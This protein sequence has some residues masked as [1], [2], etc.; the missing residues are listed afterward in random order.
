MKPIIH[1]PPIAKAPGRTLGLDVIARCEAILQQSPYLPLRRLTC[2]F[3]EGI[4]SIRGTV[5]SFHLKQQAQSALAG[6][7]G[8]EE[9][10][11]LVVVVGRHTG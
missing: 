3:H 7:P 6:V 1:T 4:L 9:L 10:Y 8:V 2:T 5:S 11:N